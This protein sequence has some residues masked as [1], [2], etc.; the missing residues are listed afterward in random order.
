MADG[1]K[2]EEPP[3]PVPDGAIVGTTRISIPI[4]AEDN[5]HMYMDEIEV[6]NALVL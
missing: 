5:F 1:A 6:W 4:F 2:V 3:L